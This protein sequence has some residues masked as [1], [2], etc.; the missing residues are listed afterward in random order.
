MKSI[1]IAAMVLLILCYAALWVA[2]MINVFN[3]LDFRKT[4]GQVAVMQLAVIGL[5]FIAELVLVG[6]CVHFN[7]SLNWDIE[8]IFRWWLTSMFI[9][10]ITLLIVKVFV[11]ITVPMIFEWLKA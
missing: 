5:G 4:L 9:F 7:D 8:I 11:P 1:K 10:V 2:L 3:N 6:I